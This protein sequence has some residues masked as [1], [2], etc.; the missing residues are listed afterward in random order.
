MVV[1]NTPKQ[2]ILERMLR[3][4][5]HGESGTITEEM[6]ISDDLVSLVIPRRSERLSCPPERY[7][8]GLFFMDVDEPTSYEESSTCVDSANWHLAM[9]SEMN[10]IWHN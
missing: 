1:V 3:S 9:E 8:F 2:V 4:S 7:S 6:I 5:P 10:S